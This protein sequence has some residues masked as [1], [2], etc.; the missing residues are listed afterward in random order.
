MT[1]QTKNIIIIGS[2]I[3]LIGAGIGAYYLFFKDKEDSTIPDLDKLAKD[4]GKKG[5]GLGE[6]DESEYS[7]NNLIPG[8]QILKTG[9]SGRKIAV[10]QALLNHYKGEKLVIDGD[11]GAKT[12]DALIKHRYCNK[13]TAC[14]MTIT[15]FLTL[16][17]RTETD[18]TF[19]QTYSPNVNAA[20]KAVYE[21]YSS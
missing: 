1:P 21:K 18:P 3:L 11:F 17:K 2:S 20:M 7:K 10:L 19:K 8:S 5:G 13:L 16:F 15:E 9:A 4:L 14:E 6:V 12:R